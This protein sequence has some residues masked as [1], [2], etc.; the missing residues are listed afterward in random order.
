[1]LK[2]EYTLLAICTPLTYLAYLVI[3]A[4]PF[5]FLLPCVVGT[6][7]NRRGE[8]NQVLNLCSK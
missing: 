4:S 2:L 7:A 6:L 5:L 1:M 3:V 8:E